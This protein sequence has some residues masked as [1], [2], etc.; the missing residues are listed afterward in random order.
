MLNRRSPRLKGWDYGC[1][2]D[3]FITAVTRGRLALFGSIGEDGILT[4]SDVGE[5]AEHEWWRS[6]SLCRGAE[7][8]AF[9]V[10]PDHV[11]GIVSLN[12]E[13]DDQ[14]GDRRLTAFV[15][16]YKAAV[17]RHAGR[18]VWQRSFFDR[19][20]RS[21]AEFHA[22]IEYIESDPGLWA[23]RHENPVLPRGRGKPHPYDLTDRLS[24][25]R[26][27]RCGRGKPLPYD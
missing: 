17:S 15:G 6:V 10:M 8:P 18:P 19:I 5:I 24:P 26:S 23:E 3:Y 11:H 16:S 21:E 12:S 9:V 7:S 27:R 2:A 22:L 13:S 25:D 14:V 4:R 20:I 1:V